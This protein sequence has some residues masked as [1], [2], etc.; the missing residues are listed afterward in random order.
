MGM[1]TILE[2]SSIVLIAMGRT[3]ARAVQS[4]F[5]GSVSTASPV[6]FLQLHPEVHVIVDH[7]AAASLPRL[8]RGLSPGPPATV[9]VL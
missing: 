5:T 8:L 3:K 1:A 4:L 6:S 2:A 9:E 7:A